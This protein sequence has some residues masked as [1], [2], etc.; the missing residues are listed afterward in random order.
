MSDILRDIEVVLL[1]FAFV[2]L[3][4]E[5]AQVIGLSPFIFAFGKPEVTRPFH[6]SQH[7]GNSRIGLVRISYADHL[8]RVLRS[9]AEIRT[10]ISQSESEGWIAFL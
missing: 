4:F 8:Q 9:Y 6:F 3:L 5:L 10:V 2:V 7:D 1:L